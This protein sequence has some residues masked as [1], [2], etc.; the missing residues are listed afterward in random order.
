[1]PWAVCEVGLKIVYV[2]IESGNNELLAKAG[3]RVTADQIVQ[4]LLKNGEKRSEL[5]LMLVE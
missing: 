2:G 3:K 1:M 4:A 5:K